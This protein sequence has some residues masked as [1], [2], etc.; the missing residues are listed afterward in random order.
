MAWAVQLAMGGAQLLTGAEE[1]DR[2]RNDS[3]V[4]LAMRKP[5]K[6]PE[7][8]YKILQATEYNAQ[9]GLDPVTLNYLTNQ[10]DRAFTSALTTSQS[11]GADPND[12]SALFDQKM[13]SVLKIGAE[14][15]ALNMENFSKYLGALN[16]ISSSKDAEWLD[17]ENKVKDRQQ[18]A[19]KAKEQA[20]QQ[21]SEGLNT[22]VSG[23]GQA[24]MSTMY[25]GKEEDDSLK[26][27]FNNE[28]GTKKTGFSKEKGT[29]KQNYRWSKKLGITNLNE[30]NTFQDQLGKLNFFN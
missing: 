23:I 25:Q 13:Q 4:A 9:N 17:L 19:A 7:E 8:L 1:K 15:H 22:I 6:T 27:Q 16:V 2:A 5:Y 14:N 18:Q 20:T 11:L 26:D 21:M 3:K 24:G 30:Y 28:F 12:I 10:T 29:G